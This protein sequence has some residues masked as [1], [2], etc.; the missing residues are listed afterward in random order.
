M[1]GEWASV[2]K[3]GSRRHRP[4]GDALT[5]QPAA[6]LDRKLSLTRLLQIL[7]DKGPKFRKWREPAPAQLQCAMG[8]CPDSSLPT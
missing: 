8:L 3:A 6:A 4:E 2:G 1:E 5:S 7:L